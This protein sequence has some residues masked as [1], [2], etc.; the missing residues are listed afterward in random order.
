MA[1]RGRKGDPLAGIKEYNSL[2][3]VQEVAELGRMVADMDLTPLQKRALIVKV[4]PQAIFWSEGR[5]AE[6][7]KVSSRQ[8][9]NLLRN[10][11]FIEAGVLLAKRYIGSRI[12][13]I[14]SAFCRDAELG[15]CTNQIKALEAVGLFLPVVDGEKAGEKITNTY[16]FNFGNSLSDE[17]RAQVDRNISAIFGQNGSRPSGSGS[18]SRF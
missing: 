6:F 8:W 12:P 2:Q 13:A 5:K 10:P 3:E 15:N 11:K 18:G 4:L 9:Y 16:I 17:E 1:K 7:A 14:A